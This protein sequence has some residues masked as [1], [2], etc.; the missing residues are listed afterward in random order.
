[1]NFESI[2]V[3]VFEPD[4]PG[5]VAAEFFWGNRDIRS[6]TP[7]DETVDVLGFQ[8]EMGDTARVCF[9]EMF[10]I[11]ENFEVTARRDLQVRAE[12]NIGPREFELQRAA[13]GGVIFKRR[14]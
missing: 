5:V 9:R 2:A 13:K 11:F 14:F 7:G 4:L 1:M 10:P 12:I 6:C 8:A 3:R